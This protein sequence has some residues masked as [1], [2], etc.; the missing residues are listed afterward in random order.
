M[1]ALLDARAPGL[2]PDLRAR[3]LAEAAGNPLA[4]VEL[5]AA[6]WPGALGAGACL[7]APVP[8]TATRLPAKSTG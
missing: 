1:V 6:W 8:M 3:L 7:S 4:L 5:P 2:E